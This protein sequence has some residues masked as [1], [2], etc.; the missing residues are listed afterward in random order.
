[1]IGVWHIRAS[2]FDSAGKA[3]GQLRG[4]RLMTMTNKICEGCGAQAL[5]EAAKF[6]P[7]CGTKLPI[8]DTPGRSV[9][10]ARPPVS[11]RE[12]NIIHYRLSQWSKWLTVALGLCAFACAAIG[13]TALQI[14]SIANDFSPASVRQFDQ[15]VSQMETAYGG[16]ALAGMASLALLACWSWRVTKNAHSLGSPKRSPG[17]AAGSWFCPFA[18]FYVPYANLKEVWEITETAAP[19]ASTKEPPLLLGFAGYWGLALL[20]YFVSEPTSLSEVSSQLNLAAV[21]CFGQ[22]ASLIFIIISVRAIS[23]RQDNLSAV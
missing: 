12:P 22:A 14:A 2:Q 8:A 7:G 6:C 23:A 18:N 9:L 20:A 16:F 4:I 13:L 5:T 15:L 10:T 21:V 11:A 1:M 3:T 19:D 17:W